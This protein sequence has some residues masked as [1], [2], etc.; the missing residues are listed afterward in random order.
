MSKL[1]IT[2]KQLEEIVNRIKESSDDD[3]NEGFLGDL[4][5]DIASFKFGN[6]GAGIKGMFSGEGYK[7]ARQ[8]N[9]INNSVAKLDKMRN[10][11]SD[12]MTH[13]RHVHVDLTELKTTD[14]YVNRMAGNLESVIQHYS[15]MRI[16]ADNLSHGVESYLKQQEQQKQQK[17]QKQQPQTP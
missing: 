2:E 7:L 15:A 13:L 17:Q 1:F 14:P 9:V 8:I 6:I 5:S 16:S 11:L 4:G 3:L 12:V 10:K